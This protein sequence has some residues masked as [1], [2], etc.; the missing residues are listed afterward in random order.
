MR[1]EDGH[2]YRRPEDDRSSDP[3]RCQ[4]MYA[5]SHTAEVS[6]ARTIRHKGTL[7]GSYN[8][9]P[10]ALGN[11]AIAALYQILLGTVPLFEQIVHSTTTKSDNFTMHLHLIMLHHYTPIQAGCWDH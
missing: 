11:R 3:E 5:F 10:E 8:V 4:P 9:W 6:D 2:I 1:Y 7:C